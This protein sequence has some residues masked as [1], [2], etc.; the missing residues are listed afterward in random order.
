MLL[1]IIYLFFEN[2]LPFNRLNLFLVWNFSNQFFYHCLTFITI[3][4]NTNLKLVYKFQTKN[5]C[6][7]FLVIV[8]LQPGLVHWA[9]HHQE[10]GDVTYLQVS[11]VL[12]ESWDGF[13][14][15]WQLSLWHVSMVTIRFWLRRFSCG[16]W[17]AKNMDDGS[18]ERLLVA[19]LM[20][21]KG[22]EEG[23]ILLEL[24]ANPA[25]SYFPP[26]I[27]Y[28]KWWEMISSKPRRQRERC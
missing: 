26:L 9:N 24:I 22:T 25:T 12:Y 4:E 6:K 5:K 15:T 17:L 13:L 20:K 23:N 10:W 3:K 2:P 21:T 19:E 27:K 14:F 7:P 16:R 1:L 8:R 28:F 11:T 18:T